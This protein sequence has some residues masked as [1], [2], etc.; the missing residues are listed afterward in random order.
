MT[1]VSS[2]KIVPPL[3]DLE[4]EFHKKED[5]NKGKSSSGVK[6]DVVSTFERNP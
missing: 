5:R 6:N 4:S 2:F 3:D 1:K